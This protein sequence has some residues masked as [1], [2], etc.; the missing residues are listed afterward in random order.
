[1]PYLRAKLIKLLEAVGLYN[2]V[3]LAYIKMLANKK[4]IVVK[5]V[6]SLEAETLEFH[7]KDRRCIILSAK[8]LMYGADMVSYF[9][10]Y[11]D[12][13]EPTVRD[14][15]SYVDFSHPAWHVLKP[16]GV[17][18]YFNSLPEP[19]VSTQ[20]YLDT[21][22]LDQCEVLIDLGSYCGGAAYF[23]AK[24]TP[25][26]CKILSLEP[27]TE[28]FAGLLRNIEFH[29]L[30]KVIPLRLAIWSEPG[31]LFFQAEGSMGS[32][33]DS[34]HNRTANSVRVEATSLQQLVDDYNLDRIDCIKMDIEGSET[35]VLR[36][37]INILTR[38]SP[39]LIIEPHV[40]N[41]IL[42]LS[43]LEGILQGIGYKTEVLSQGELQLPLL[44]AKRQS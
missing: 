24:H 8:H 34:V 3:A 27:D 38:F 2:T 4:G 9:D 19:D 22:P 7:N 29:Q 40:V 10:Y 30:T 36:S 41:G 12:S 33:V 15:V 42:N 14:G 39:T 35:V 37:S 11:H 13:V 18:L 31:A 6:R 17:K 43:E 5:K 23:F 44:L 16:S 1:M 20:I 26:S 32:G 25:P 21:L 28:N